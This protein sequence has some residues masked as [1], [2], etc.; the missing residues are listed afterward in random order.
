MLP[1][2]P[3]I[4]LNES[5]VESIVKHALESNNIEENWRLYSEMINDVFES[6]M[7]GTLSPYDFPIL[8]E[9]IDVLLSE[10]FLL[11]TFS[12]TNYLST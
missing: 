10:C 6:S 12:D 11:F 4:I 9:T 5:I 7:K 8:Y 3:A 2:C 1:V